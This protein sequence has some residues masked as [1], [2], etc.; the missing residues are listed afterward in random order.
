MIITFVY[1]VVTS[2]N[3]YL[4]LNMQMV[5]TRRTA[6]GSLVG[7]GSGQGNGGNVN[8]GNGNEGN[9]GNGA[10]PRTEPPPP[11]PGPLTAEQLL[12]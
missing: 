4:M 6:S 11:P 1:N 10:N 7:D 9:G 5:D 2:P 3:D 8:G 12:Q